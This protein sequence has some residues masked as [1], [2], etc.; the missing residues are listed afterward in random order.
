MCILWARL[1][2]ATC[3][4]CQPLWYPLVCRVKSYECSKVRRV[5]FRER[6]EIREERGTNRLQ[7]GTKTRKYG[8]GRTE[9]FKNKK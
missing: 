5:F 8:T 2:R 4:I 7:A 6:K 9:P 3:K 1:S